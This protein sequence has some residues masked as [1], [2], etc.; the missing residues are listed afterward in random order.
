MIR[1]NMR[2]A[3]NSIKGQGVGS[4]YTEQV[5]LVKNNLSDEF[6]ITE[7]KRGKYDIVHYHTINPGYF[8][9]RKLTHKKT[10]GIGYVHFLPCTLEDSLNLPKII[11]KIFYKY[12]LSFYNSMDYLVT[13]NPF[14]V[15]EIRK[16]GVDKPEVSCI[17]NFVSSDKFYPMDDNRK[18]RFRKKYGIDEDKFVVLG[19]GQLQTRKGIFDFIETAKRLP[20]IQF[21]WAGGF[22]FGAITDGYSEIKKMKNNPPANVKFLDIVPREDMPGIYNMSDV[23]FIPSYD[24]L[25]PMAILEAMCCKI[26]VVHRDIPLYKDIIPDACPKGN[27]IEEFAEIFLELYSDN[28]AME[29]WSEKVWEC[30]LNYTEDTILRQWETLYT[31]AYENNYDIS[32]IKRQSIFA[33]W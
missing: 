5:N 16:A 24:E 7:N 21:I 6:E 10:I 17:P 30:H 19:V 18:S 2:S 31:K 15:E 22:S 11:K 29:M 13:V 9:E 4:C 20:E 23:Y 26:P 27:T 33:R 14:F 28:E 3:A 12:I 25:F 32:N 1:I 8:I